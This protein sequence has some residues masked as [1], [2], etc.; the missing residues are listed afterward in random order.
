MSTVTCPIG[1]EST[2]PEWCDTCGAR[3]GGLPAGRPEPAAGAEPVAPPARTQRSAR[4]A[5]R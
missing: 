5:T 3:I 2:D 1:H 4:T